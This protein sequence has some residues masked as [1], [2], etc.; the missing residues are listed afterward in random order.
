MQAS[1]TITFKPQWQY[2]FIL[3][4]LFLYI[5]CCF[6]QTNLAIRSQLILISFMSFLF[7]LKWY[8]Y[9]KRHSQR[10]LSCQPSS[11]WY[12]EIPSTLEKIPVNLFMVF[13]SRYFMI[14]KIKNKPISTK[15][16]PYFLIL[17]I[18]KE[19]LDGYKKTAMILKSNFF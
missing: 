5:I 19:N 6:S 18:T 3:F 13:Y 17:F 4:I 11:G 15:K 12:T 14:L 10:I 2:G 8:L 9:S 7:G 1:C 16:K